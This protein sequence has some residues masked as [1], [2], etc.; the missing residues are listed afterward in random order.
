MSHLRLI[1][2]ANGS[3]SSAAN[4][5]RSAIAWALGRAW[6]PFRRRLLAPSL[7]S[8]SSA[9]EPCVPP[10]SSTSK[11]SAYMDGRP[12]ERSS[13]GAVGMC[14]GW[15]VKTDTNGRHGVCA[16]AG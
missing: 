11:P 16:I 5:C 4:C 14:E 8:S 3:A 13:E 7:S 9:S 2:G 1:L 12:F 10:S 15:G 6:R